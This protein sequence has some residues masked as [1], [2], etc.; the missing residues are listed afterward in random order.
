T[1]AA[2]Q[3]AAKP[4]AYPAINLGEDGFVAVLEVAKPATQGAVDIGNDDRQGPSVVSPRLDPNGLSQ[5]HQAFVSRP[6]T[7]VL[8]TIAEEFKRTI[9]RIDDPRLGRVQREAGLRHPRRH[10]VQRGL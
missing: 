3:Q 1:L 2:T 8:K 4:P 5:L 6:A 9:L 10:R 7:A